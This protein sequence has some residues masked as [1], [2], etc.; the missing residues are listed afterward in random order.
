MITTCGTDSIL[1][2]WHLGCELEHCVAN[3]VQ[4]L[5][6]RTQKQITR[7]KE[8]AEKKVKKELKGIKKER[9]K[10]N[11]RLEREAEA[12]RIYEEQVR[13]LELTPVIVCRLLNLI[14]E[15]SELNLCS[16]SPTRKS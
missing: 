12:N 1:R 10:R 5:P 14:L 4:V 9:K 11:R 16:I 6:P 15:V 7:M 8:K 2:V 13:Q 3:V